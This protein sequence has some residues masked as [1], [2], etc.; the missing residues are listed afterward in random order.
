LSCI[1]S[2]SFP[3]RAGIYTAVAAITVP[4]ED[5]GAVNAGD[6]RSDDN[7]ALSEEL[8]GG[9]AKGAPPS[10][11]FMYDATEQYDGCTGSYPSGTLLLPGSASRRGPNRQSLRNNTSLCSGSGAGG[12]FGGAAAAAGAAGN[13]FLDS[14]LS[15]PAHRTVSNLAAGVDAV[16]GLMGRLEQQVHHRVSGQLSKLVSEG[17]RRVEE[18][19]QMLAGPAGMAQSPQQQ[20]QQL[21]VL[22]NDSVQ[23]Q[24][25]IQKQ[26]QAGQQ[27]TQMM[28]SAGQQS[29]TS[30]SSRSGVSGGGGGGGG[31]GG[32]ARAGQKAQA[33]P[34]LRDQA[35]ENELA[36]TKVDVERV[37]AD[38]Q[39]FVSRQNM[40]LD[41]HR[42]QSEQ[43]RLERG[44][45]AAFWNAPEQLLCDVQALRDRLAAL[46]NSQ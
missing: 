42:R 1:T 32:S 9:S 23:Q 14:V 37:L 10:I 18:L 16:L 4:D 5:A 39:V 35:F 15:D 43:S 19:R 24:T 41:S 6:S 29:S 38:I 17:R 12:G 26:P 40:L 33:W 21:L 44:V 28:A 36:G 45:L 3:F 46:L 25:T 31:G 27:T 34:V 22:A 2:Y 8:Y 20:Q 11:A 7:D 13:A 30:A